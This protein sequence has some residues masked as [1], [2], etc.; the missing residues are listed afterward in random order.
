MKVELSIAWAS[1]F[2]LFLSFKGK[3]HLSI[4]ICTLVEFSVQLHQWF[5]VF[6]LVKFLSRKK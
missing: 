2:K 4:A 3:D 5:G 6:F 1:T